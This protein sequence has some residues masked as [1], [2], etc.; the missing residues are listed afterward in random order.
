[1]AEGDRSNLSGEEQLDLNRQDWEY[2][3]KLVKILAT[4]LIIASF[5]WAGCEVLAKC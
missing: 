4:A 3:L 2:G 5:F 1:M